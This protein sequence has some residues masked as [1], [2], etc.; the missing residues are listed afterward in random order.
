M[1]GKRRWCSK[2]CAM[3]AQLPSAVQLLPTVSKLS[4]SAAP[5]ARSVCMMQRQQRV[6]QTSGTLR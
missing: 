6:Q 4:W 5:R 2:Q 1:G 3:Q